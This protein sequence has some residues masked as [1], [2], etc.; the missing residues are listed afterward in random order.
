[1][2]D[3]EPGEHER[4]S[5]WRSQPFRRF[6]AGNAVSS[7]GDQ[8]TSLA[9]PFIAV[10]ELDATPFHVGLLTA[11]LWAPSLLALF[12]G[13]WVDAFR[14]RRQLLILANMVQASALT[15]VPIAFLVGGL[16]M[17]VLYACALAL[18]L[19]GVLFDSAYPS[20]FVQLVRRDQYVPANS[21]L[22]S[23]LGVASVGGPAVAGA[24]IQALGA[25]FAIL[26]DAV[27]FVF[28]AIVI[29]AVRVRV[30]DTGAE[31]QEPEP[32]GRRL[33]MGVMYLRHHAILRASLFASATMNL[34]SL[35]IQA[36]LVLYATRALGLGPAE[37]GV[38][39]GVGAAGGLIG[40]VTAVPLSNHIGNGRAI[41]L[42]VALNALP[43]LALPLASAHHFNGFV[44]LCVAEAVSSWAIMQFDVNNNSLRAAVTQ[45]D[46]RARVSGAYSTVNYGIRPIGAFAAGV[47][48][49][50]TGAGAVIA[51]AACVGSLAVLWLLPSPILRVRRIADL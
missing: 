10:T 30:R 42:G 8:I 5:L 4:P 1:M 47:V 20:F 50:G 39:L 43:Y 41:A 9:L 13:T 28:S 19:G 33:A 46:M 11:A 32:F 29:G 49:S 3:K 44:A 35:A 40:A 38:A 22:S 18:G 27:S 23:T 51:V 21:A 37:I 45:D 24:L 6:W 15:T 48:A 31:A 7:F 12:I 36:L 2:T 17:P 25:P 16:S 26:A 34:A 14:Q